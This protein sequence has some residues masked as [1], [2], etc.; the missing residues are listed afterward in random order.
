MDKKIC[1]ITGAN[2]GIGKE[3]ARQ[4]SES[5][6]HVILACRSKERGLKALKEIKTNSLNVSVELM[7]VDMSLMDSVKYFSKTYKEKYGRLD[8]LINNAAYFDITQ[9]ERIVTSEGIEKVWA[10]NHLGPV[11]L[12]ENLISLLKES[13]QGRLINVASKGLLMYPYL[14]VN[15]DDPEFRNRKFSIAKAY[16]QSKLAQIMY[17]YWISNKYKDASFTA[18]IIR[19]TNVKVDLNRFPNLSDFVKR[20]YSF[21]SKFSISADEMAKT[22]RYLAVS[23]DVSNLSGK[24]ITEKNVAVE[25]SAYSKNKTEIKKVIDLTWKYLYN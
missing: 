3:A 19:V 15:L 23:P 25:T 6:Y 8:V 5:N 12:A 4:I 9:K 10:T 13:K 21:K 2:S 17:T 16:Y 14:K 24:Y 7:I 20:I 18:N 22:Y 1:I 11:C